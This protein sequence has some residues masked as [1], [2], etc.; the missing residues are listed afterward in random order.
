MTIVHKTHMKL[1]F[2]HGGKKHQI[3]HTVVK[4][5]KKILEDAQDMSVGRILFPK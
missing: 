2:N 4:E 1:S 3:N 5:D